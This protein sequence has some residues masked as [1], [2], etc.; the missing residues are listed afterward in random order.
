M[1]QENRTAHVT[2]EERREFL[3]GLGL[4]GGLAAGGVGLSEIREHVTATPNHDLAA[5][6]EG[7]R[8]EFSGALD[9]ALLA[10]SRGTFASEA[11]ALPAVVEK[12]LPEAR[13]RADFAP[14]AAAGRPAYEHLVESGFFEG[15]ASHLPEF[16]PEFVASAAETFV[17]SESAAAPL[18]DTGFDEREAADLVAAV[19]SGRH[20]LSE[21]LWI[22]REDVPAAVVGGE[23]V[24]PMPQQA[25]GGALLWFADLDTYLAQH[26]VLLTE[27]I[28]GDATRDAHAMAGGFQLMTAAAEDLARGGE[29]SDAELGAMLTTGLALQDIAQFLL[30]D[31]AYWVT[32]EMRG[33]RST[34]IET[35]TEELS[36]IVERAEEAR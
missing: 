25:A 2:D 16:S 3:K 27:E 20:R 35:E 14:V 1:E 24:P 22:S 36:A 28:L 34:D 8:A 4:A 23:Y 17:A 11:S 21:Q 12:G 31:E 10:D 15:V 6:A 26:R 13:A 19:V 30:L 18:A 9:T 32:E 5:V 29:R 7:L 33:E